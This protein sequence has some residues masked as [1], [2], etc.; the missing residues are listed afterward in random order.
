MKKKDEAYYHRRRHRVRTLPATEQAD[1]VR[2][3]RDNDL[4][5]GAQEWLL[6]LADETLRAIR[7]IF[8]MIPGRN[9]SARI[10][11]FMKVTDQIFG[12]LARHEYYLA[13]GPGKL[14]IP[15]YVERC[16][17]TKGPIDPVCLYRND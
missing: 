10:I 2:W 15:D 8:P 4:D 12:P 9:N 7:Y 6:S 13:S 17:E 16:L 14:Q 5:V 1:W 3:V 11:S